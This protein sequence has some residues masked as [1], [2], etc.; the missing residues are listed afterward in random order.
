LRRAS[1]GD[2]RIAAGRVRFRS[3]LARTQNNWL[4][5]AF[6]MPRPARSITSNASLLATA[7]TETRLGACCA[8]WSASNSISTWPARTLAPCSTFGV[9]AFASKLNRIDTDMHQDFRALRRAQSHRVMGPREMRDDTIAGREQHAFQRIDA[10]TIAEHAVRKH[11]IGDIGERTIG[12]VNGARQHDI[13]RVFGG[14][15]QQGLPARRI[16]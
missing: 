7:I 13:V 14:M 9:K 15:I 8:T 3:T 11:R 5:P 16:G 1:F 4:S 10:D 12:P 6:S 2:I